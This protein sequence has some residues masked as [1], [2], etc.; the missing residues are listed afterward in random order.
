MN[1]GETVN[2]G[3]RFEAGREG[4]GRNQISFERKSFITFIITI[5]LKESTMEMVDF[6]L[7]F[8]R[9]CVAGADAVLQTSLLI[10]N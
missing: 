4:D 5:E 8:N 3:L 2:K 1:F 9:T 10:F 7:V 6:H